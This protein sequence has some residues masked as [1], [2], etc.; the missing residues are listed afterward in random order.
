MPKK[1]NDKNHKV[2]YKNSGVSIEKADIL[3]NKIKPLAKNTCD[4][5]VIGNILDFC[6][7]LF[8]KKASKFEI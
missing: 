7:Q 8:Y 1:N 5:N 6:Y 4:N 3:I 2:T